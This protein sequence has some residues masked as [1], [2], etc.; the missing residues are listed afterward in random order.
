MAHSKAGGHRGMEAK[1]IYKHTGQKT[2]AVVFDEGD[3]FIS[4][5]KEFA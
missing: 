4:R 3:E 2:I 5:L 1:L